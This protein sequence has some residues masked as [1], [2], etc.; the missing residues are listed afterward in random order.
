MKRY[1]SLLR[2]RHISL[3][4]YKSDSVLISWMTADFLDT[5][6]APL[7]SFEASAQSEVSSNYNCVLR[8][9]LE[10]LVYSFEKSNFLDDIVM[11]VNVDENN[12]FLF[13]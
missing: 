8:E 11:C 9:F 12:D 7:L 5:G 6:I 10:L 13:Q 3:R 1:F 4:L 2:L